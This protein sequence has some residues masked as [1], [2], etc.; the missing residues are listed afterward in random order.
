MFNIKVDNIIIPFNNNF[1]WS[2][3]N[4]DKIAESSINK[5][6]LHHFQ[7]LRWITKLDKNLVETSEESDKP[8]KFISLIIDSF[9]N[10]FIN[11][12]K[13]LLKEKNFSITN[14]WFNDHCTSI[15]LEKLT[16]L[17]N[18]LK[19]YNINYSI[20]ESI[21]KIHIKILIVNRDLSKQPV[22]NWSTLGKGV[23]IDKHNHGL[24]NSLS[25]IKVLYK[26]PKLAPKEILELSYKRYKEQLEWLWTTDGCTREHSLA[27]QCFN[28]NS[29]LELLEIINTYGDKYKYKNYL[30]NLIDNVQ[31][32]ILYSI[33]YNREFFQVGDT[34]TGTP[35]KYILKDLKQKKLLNEDINEIYFNNNFK[36]L[37]NKIFCSKES[38]YFILRDDKF[39]L[40][41]MASYFSRIHKQC[42]DLHISLNINNIQLLVDAG[43]SDK[44]NKL[45]YKSTSTRQYHNT[46]IL[47][48]EFI[49]NDYNKQLKLRSNTKI[50]NYTNF[51]D[52][53]IVTGE[54]IIKNKY[55]HKRIL[56]I[57]PKYHVIVIYDITDYPE[58]MYQ[59]FNFGEKIK[60][61]SNNINTII[62]ND[63]D[64]FEFIT[65][66]AIKKSSSKIWIDRFNTTENL[67]FFVKFSKSNMVIIKEKDIDNI[68][69]ININN[70]NKLTYEINSIIK[71]I[72]I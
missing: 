65:S 49:N 36:Q 8:W 26:M 32:L 15:R 71:Y 52:G 55:F 63:T 59:V 40:F 14:T 68:S 19:E 10:F 67:R 53:Y 48:E 25:I 54:T 11:N 5:I 60:F 21:L 56:I 42:D 58:Y 46:V 29:I 47:Q 30:L 27:Y 16:E 39:H 34:Y 9:L 51:E 37:K 12:Y 1:D 62:G 18:K 33:Q 13:N 50:I 35:H 31:Y 64:K 3:N 43:Y 57:F 4:L 72:N 45:C 7:S 44:Q 69:N 61:F 17:Y 41:F 66:K 6:W 20:Y 38:G 24:M 70:N 22:L 2:Q 28:I 23:Y